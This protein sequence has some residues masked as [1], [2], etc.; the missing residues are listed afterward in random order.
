MDGATKA[1]MAAEEIDV[2]GIKNGGSTLV[3]SDSTMPQTPTHDSW[4][5]NMANASSSS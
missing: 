4:K 5:S 2:V 1:S 3:T